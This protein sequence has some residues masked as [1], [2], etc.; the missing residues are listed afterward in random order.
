[1]NA[2]KA[3]WQALG[4]KFDAK[5]QR[6]RL[7]LAVAAVGG[8]WLLGNSLLVDPALAKVRQTK[9]AVA[10]QEGELA[11]VQAQTGVVRGQLQAD[12]DAGRKADIARLNVRLKELEGDLKALEDRFIPPEQMNGLLES[13]L[14]N[15]ARLRLV[16]LKSLAPTNLAEAAKAKVT[17]KAP[18]NPVQV[19]NPLGLYKH[20]VELRLEGSYADLYAWLAQLESNQKKIL[21]GD[22]RFVVTEHPRSVMTLVVYTLSTD[23]AWLSI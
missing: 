13:L 2:I 3:R 10:Q 21:W 16:S 1:M 22:V 6:E 18:E 19:A 4:A 23:K 8:V 7:L 9:A 5:A 12:P 17:E 20:G 15:N 11:T 14:S